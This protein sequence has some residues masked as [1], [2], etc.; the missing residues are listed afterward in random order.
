M[1][2]PGRP[3]PSY[4]RYLGQVL[5]AAAPGLLVIY[6]FKDVN[7]FSGSRGIRELLSAAVVALLHLWRRSMLLSIASGTLVYMFLI[8]R[9]F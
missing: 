6:S 7:R 8:Q 9:V 4:V 5:P 1:F 2:P 3:T